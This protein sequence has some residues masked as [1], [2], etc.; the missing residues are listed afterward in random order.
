MRQRGEDR[1][2]KTAAVAF[3]AHVIVEELEVCRP[4]AV[5][6]SADPLERLPKPLRA[7]GRVVSERPRE[8]VLLGLC[9]ALS[10]ELRRKMR[11]SRLL[12][13]A[14]DPVV[15][16]PTPL[17]GVRLVGNRLVDGQDPA[18]VT[19]LRLA[20]PAHANRESGSLPLNFHAAVYPA[21]DHGLD[22]LLEE[23]ADLFPR[24]V[25]RRVRPR[26]RRVRVAVRQPVRA[27][28][29]RPRRDVVRLPNPPNKSPLDIRAKLSSA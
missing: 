18:I 1:A 16:P 6:R 7:V 22:P 23:V 21:R 14:G 24:V 27:A 25:V 5:G 8:D 19:R 26:P 2:S 29:G 28:A 15:R 17:R 20:T 9:T 4:G 3:R 12:S 11:S 10:H 13:Y